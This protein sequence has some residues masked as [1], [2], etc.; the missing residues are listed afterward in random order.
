M[1]AYEKICT[2]YEKLKPFIFAGDKSIQEE[3]EDH[4][5][6]IKA[7]TYMIAKY[8]AGFLEGKRRYHKVLE[9]RQNKKYMKA[10]DKMTFQLANLSTRMFINPYGKGTA[11]KLFD[12]GTYILE[13]IYAKFLIFPK[14]K[15]GHIVLAYCT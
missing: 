11:R 13:N 14:K 3:C 7:F 4:V 10:V 5:D 9:T 8:I 6:K 12:I 1:K 15:N 2:Q